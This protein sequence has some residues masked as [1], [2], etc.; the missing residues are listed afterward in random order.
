MTLSDDIARR[1]ALAEAATPGPWRA[2]NC[3]HTL[4]GECWHVD[5][6]ADMW[7]TDCQGDTA[8]FIAAHHPGIVKALWDVVEAIQLL[9]ETGGWRTMLV[10][11]E[12]DG[13][14]GPSVPN[15][16]REIAYKA[17]DALAAAMREQQS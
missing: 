16:T 5:P 17:L 3:N 1:R 8:A 4:P 14:C 15:A 10:T 2:R 7:E 9:A 6:V 13:S 11:D 12:A